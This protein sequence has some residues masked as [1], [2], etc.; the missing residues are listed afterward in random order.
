M[1]SHVTVT[2]AVIEGVGVLDLIPAAHHTGDGRGANC[3]LS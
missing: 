3:W 1:I 2:H